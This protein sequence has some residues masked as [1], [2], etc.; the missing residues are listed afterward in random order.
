MNP[1]AR[2]GCF[3]PSVS[4]RILF[5]AGASEEQ[6]FALRSEVRAA[7]RLLAK[8]KADDEALVS[9]AP[10]ALEAEDSAGVPTVRPHANG[11]MMANRFV[12]SVCTARSRRADR[13]TD[14]VAPST[15]Q[16]RLR[17][18][19][20]RSRTAYGSA[21]DRS[22]SLGASDL[23]AACGNCIRSAQHYARRSI[24]RGRPA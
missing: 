18:S 23:I 8:A 11:P 13:Q 22:R 15:A 10:M 20:F 7:A 16:H 5:D 2:A 4:W 21:R 6:T 17:L 19:A 14:T 24:S 9:K 3:A 1:D 12:Q